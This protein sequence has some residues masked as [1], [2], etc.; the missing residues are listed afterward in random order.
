MLLTQIA[1]FALAVTMLAVAGCG[2]SSK[3]TSSS[4]P[5]KAPTSTAAATVSTTITP[6]TIV[7]VASGKPLT[8][9]QWIAKGDAICSHMN[10]QIDASPAVESITDYARVLP[11]VAVYN[12]AAAAELSKLVPPA[13]KRSDWNRVVKD[14]QLVGEYA[15]RTGEYAQANNLTAFRSLLNKGQTFYTQAAAITKRDGF[16][17]CSNGS[18]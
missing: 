17:K 9:A 2:G 8:R 11:Q 15:V 18:T 13:S 4:K 12:K 16:K 7:T 1:A 3:T 6:A 14:I 5:A 10:K